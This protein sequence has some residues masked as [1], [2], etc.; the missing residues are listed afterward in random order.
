MGMMDEKKRI[1][2]NILIMFLIVFKAWSFK[3]TLLEF[4]INN[5]GSKKIHLKMFKKILLFKISSKSK[6]NFVLSKNNVYKN[7]FQL[8]F[9][10]IITIINLHYDDDAKSANCFCAVVA[11]RRNSDVSMFCP[12]ACA[13][14]LQL[15]SA[16][17]PVVSVS[18]ASSG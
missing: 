7:C 2:K 1:N 16:G 3:K 8:K 10:P 11:F 9:D 5:L 17:A 13:F 18:P 4:V 6:K 12:A 14:H 15:Q